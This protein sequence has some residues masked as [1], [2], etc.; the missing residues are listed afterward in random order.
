MY[1]NEN[2]SPMPEKYFKRKM[3]VMDMV[4]NPARTLFLKYAE[5][6]GAKTIPGISM[7]LN[8]ARSQFKIWTGKIP[9]FP[10]ERELENRQPFAK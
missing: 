10:S 8:Q 9:D 6:A 4:Y 2:E 1:G 3:I 7:Y 5:K